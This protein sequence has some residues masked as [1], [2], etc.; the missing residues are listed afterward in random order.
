MT[1][2]NWFIGGVAS[3]F[4]AWGMNALVFSWLVVGVLE[5]EARYIG[6]AQTST[7]LPSL[8]LLLWGGALADR[9][10]PR[11]VLIVL[12][13]ACTVPILALSSL[14]GSGGLTLGILLLYGATLGTLQAFVMPARDALL[15]RIDALLLAGGGDLDPQHYQGRP[16][17][18]IYMTDAERDATELQL[19]RA[20]VESIFYN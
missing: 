8:L 20:V 12:H 19:A 17:E 6:I 5:A 4:T 11:R 14:I 16:H 3:W 7:M 13:L 10:D 2:H 15:S 1:S 9:L 18:S